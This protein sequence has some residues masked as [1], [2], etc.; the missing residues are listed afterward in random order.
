MVLWDQREFQGDP[1]LGGAYSRTLTP[2]NLVPRHRDSQ[3][4][5]LWDLLGMRKSYYW[6]SRIGLL[7]QLIELANNFIL[8]GLECS[9]RFN[10][11]KE[12]RP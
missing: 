1:R 11:V 4:A 12:D 5:F 3:T 9:G 7:L 10:R 2:P 6:F 8:G